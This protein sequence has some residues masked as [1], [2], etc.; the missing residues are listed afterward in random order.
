M[1]KQP[2]CS[3]LVFHNVILISFVLLIKLPLFKYLSAKKIFQF[4]YILRKNKARLQ[5]VGFIF[6]DILIKDLSFEE[7]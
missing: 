3:P 2:K 4:V 7:D 5:R 1:K 6:L